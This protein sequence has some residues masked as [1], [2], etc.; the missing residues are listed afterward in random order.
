MVV[1]GCSSSSSQKKKNNITK[2]TKQKRKFKGNGKKKKSKGKG[3]CFIYGQKG[4]QKKKKSPKFLKRQSS[5]HHYLLVESCLVLDSTNSWWTDF[6]ATNHVC[7]LLLGFQLRIRMNDG[8]MLMTLAF[9]ARVIVQAMRD[10]TLI[11][12]NNSV[13]VLK[14]CLYV[15]K[16]RK[17]LIWVSSL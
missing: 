12:S 7:N 14:N 15:P 2:S 11:F 4:H 17:N 5:I 8:D 16:S 6:R 3:K 10:I 13:L 1:K 9:E